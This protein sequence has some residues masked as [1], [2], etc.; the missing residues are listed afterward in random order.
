MEKQEKHKNCFNPFVPNAPFLYPLKTSENLTIFLCFQGGR[1][2]V[3]WERIGY[4]GE[5]N[6]IK[7]GDFI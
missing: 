7:R 6:E 1:E 3:H 4:N 2:R 5:E